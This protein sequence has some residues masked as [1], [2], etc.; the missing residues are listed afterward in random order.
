MDPILKHGDQGFQNMVYVA[1]DFVW[2]LSLPTIK[3][4]GVW[5]LRLETDFQQIWGDMNVLANV[6]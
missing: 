6:R 4:C 3:V 1:F 2:S 5:Q